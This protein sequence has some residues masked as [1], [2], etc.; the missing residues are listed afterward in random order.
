M[1][2]YVGSRTGNDGINGAAMAS[3]EFSS[4]SNMEELKSNIQ[5]G[6]AFLE[7]VLLEA[8]LEI[9]NEGL[10]QGLNVEDRWFIMFIG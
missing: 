8:C 3:E 4:D 6:D 1:L 9:V 2:I 10:L 5:K 7:K